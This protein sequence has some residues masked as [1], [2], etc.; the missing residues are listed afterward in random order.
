M[1]VDY[2]LATAEGDEAGQQD[3]VDRLLAYAEEL[4]ATFETL[5]D[6]EL[7]ASASHPPSR[8]TSSR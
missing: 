2:T 7:P 3:A 8:S 5:T 6:G 4:A 1:F